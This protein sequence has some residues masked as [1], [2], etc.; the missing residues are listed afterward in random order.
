MVNEIERSNIA[1]KFQCGF[2]FQMDG[3]FLISGYAIKYLSRYFITKTQTL[4]MI[5]LWQKSTPEAAVAK[6]IFSHMEKCATPRDTNN[7]QERSQVIT[8]ANQDF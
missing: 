6:I 3:E 1:N 8:K 5:F 2:T 7:I 4:C